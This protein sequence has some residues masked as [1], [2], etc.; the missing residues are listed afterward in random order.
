MCLSWYDARSYL[1]VPLCD[2]CVPARGAQSVCPV[3]LPGVRQ[4]GYYTADSAGVVSQHG[5][6]VVRERGDANAWSLP[7]C[8][9]TVCCSGL[10]LAFSL[11]RRLVCCPATTVAW[12]LLRMEVTCTCWTCGWKLVARL[13]GCRLR[14]VALCVAQPSPLVSRPNRQRL[15]AW[16]VDAAVPRCAP[17]QIQTASQAHTW[18]WGTFVCARSV[19]CWHTMRI[20]VWAGRSSEANQVVFLAQL[21]TVLRVSIPSPPVAMAGGLFMID[22]HKSRLAVACVDGRLRYLIAPASSATGYTWHDGVRFDTTVRCIAA[23]PVEATSPAAGAATSASD[24]DDRP[25]SVFCGGDWDG[26][27]VVHGDKVVHRIAMDDWAVALSCFTDSGADGVTTHIVAAALADGS[28]VVA[29][30]TT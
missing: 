24:S 26:V 6:G 4:V 7:R 15:M 13:V 25:C 11:N 21:K 18:L 30:S 8:S 16:A 28:V 10:N 12:L 29:S 27:S 2:A 17:Y 1:H 20:D 19:E 5:T 23:S 22:G 3:V 9:R 14:L